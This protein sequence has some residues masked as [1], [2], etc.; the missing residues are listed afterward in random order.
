MTAS[1]SSKLVAS[2]QRGLEDI[3]QT[4]EKSKRKEHHTGNESDFYPV[5]AHVCSTKY[6]PWFVIPA[7]H[8]WFRNLAVSQIIA[9][10]VRT[11]MS[12]HEAFAV[13]SVCHRWGYRNYETPDLSRNNVIVGLW[14]SGE[15]WHN[16]HHAD[17][18][19][20]RHGHAWWEFDF[21]WLTAANLNV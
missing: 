17:P 16:N 18:N 7:N 5:I 6:A 13:N 9:G 8:K 14:A 21:R 15:G 20:T 1:A 10:A 2:G 19:S 11:T 12:W 3:Q 4:D